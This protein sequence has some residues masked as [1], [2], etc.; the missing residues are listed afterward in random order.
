MRGKRHTKD[1]CGPH[2]QTR[3]QDSDFSSKID[4]ICAAKFLHMLWQKDFFHL[5]QM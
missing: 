1:C 3:R 2:V 5:C 4:T